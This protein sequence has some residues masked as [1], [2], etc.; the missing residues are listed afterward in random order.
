MYALGLVKEV[1][2]RR[3]VLRAPH[4]RD[5]PGA[6]ATVIAATGLFACEV[7]V[8]VLGHRY[9][10]YEDVRGEGGSALSPGTRDEVAAACSELCGGGQPECDLWWGFCE[11]ACESVLFPGCEGAATALIRCLAGLP[12]ES[13]QGWESSCGVEVSGLV[14]CMP[15]DACERGATVVGPGECSVSGICAGSVLSQDCYVIDGERFECVC[16]RGTELVESCEATEVSCD[17]SDCC[18]ST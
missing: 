13:C 5:R 18:G 2:E 16:H 8:S 17:L 7:D 11:T 3:R 14:D 1:V 12:R 15:V 4:R 10:P 6:L 9:E